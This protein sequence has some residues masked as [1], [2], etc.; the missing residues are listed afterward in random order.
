MLGWH[1][2]ELKGM[3][4]CA[5][6]QCRGRRADA[7]HRRAQNRARAVTP[8]VMRK[9]FDASA[10]RQTA[11]EQR[12]RNGVDNAGLSDRNH[13]RGNILVT[14]RRREISKR[15]CFTSHD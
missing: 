8:D 2:I 6:G 13:R 3:G 12:D 10:P 15:S 11:A 4:K 7:T 14:Q 9:I 5:V 1:I